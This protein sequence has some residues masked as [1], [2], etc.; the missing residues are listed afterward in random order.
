MSTF[1]F[2]RWSR[3]R[4]HAKGRGLRP[5]TRRRASRL[6]QLE[7]RQLLAAEL[8]NLLT[9][10]HVDLNLQHESGQWQLGVEADET[11]GKVH[12]TNDQAL[13]YAGSPARVVMPEGAPLDFVGVDPGENFYLLPQSQAQNAEALFLG[14]AGYGLDDTVDRYDASAES[15]GRT[16]A[17]QVR[18]AKAALADVRHVNPD[19]SAGSG[20]FSMWQS[21]VF[22]QTVVFM[23]SFDDGVANANALG[24]DTTDG[25]SADDAVWISTGSHAHYNFGFTQPGRYEVDLRLS[26]Y[27]GDDNSTTPNS[28]GF[29]Q[30]DPITVY[31]SVE[32]VGQVQFDASSYSVDEDA[33]TA[34]IDVVRTGGSDGRIS[35]NYATGDATAVA[36]SD[37]TPMSGEIVLADGQT[38]KTIEIPILDDATAEG[39][40]S[41]HVGLMTPLPAGID[42]YL[43]QSEDDANGLLGDVVS[44]T[45]TIRANDGSF[46]V[47]GIQESYLPGEVL[48][49]R[50]AGV[51][52]EEGQE[53]QWRIRPAGTD[54]SG[55]VLSRFVPE[56][57]TPDARAGLLDMQL[58]ASFDGYELVAAVMQDFQAIATTKWAGPITVSNAVEPLSITYNG[59]TP[60]RIGETASLVATGRELVEGESLK[61]VINASLDHYALWRSA[62]GYDQIDARTFAF[63]PPSNNLYPLALQV[64]R[65][66]LVV[67]QSESFE[68]DAERVEFFFE[69][70]QP[71]YRAGQTFSAMITVDP[72]LGDKVTYSWAM[73]DDDQNPM[74]VAQGEAGRTFEMPLTAD[75]DG[76]RMYIQ[77]RV[78]YESGNTALVGG[79]YPYLTVID[80]ASD[81]L[82]L[83]SSL[84]DHYHQGSPVDLQLFADPGLGEGDSIAWQ[85]RW[86]GMDWETMPGAEG[87][88]HQLTAEQAMDGLEVRATLTFANSN[89]DPMAAGPVTIEIDDHGSAPLQQPT[90]TG[91]LSVIGDNLVTLTRQLPT[92]VGT[93]LTSHLWERKGAGESTFSPVAG[94][95][96]ST[97]TFAA[98]MADDGAEY[99]VS[100]LKPDGTVAY[101]PSP[102]VVLD[103]TT[104]PHPAA[105]VP[106]A[107]PATLSTAPAGPTGAAL[108]DLDGDGDED[109]LV[110]SFGSVAWLP[111]DAGTF[112][113]S[114]TVAAVGADEAVAGD[115]DGDGDLDVIV[116][117][118]GVGL[119]WYPN[120]GSGT[121]GSR[122]V[123]VDLP[124]VSPGTLGVSLADLDGDGDL[125]AVANNREP[126]EVT[127]YANDGSGN[128]AMAAAL[129]FDVPYTFGLAFADL[130][131]D[132]D[133]D[134]AAANFPLNQILWA[135]ND[136]D[137]NFGLTLTVTS[138][139]TGP[140][141]VIAVDLDGDSDLDLVSA[142][143]DDKVA[144]YENDGSGNFGPQQILT[145]A[146]LTP[147]RLTAEDLNGDGG[148]DVIVGSGA[149]GD[150]VWLPGNGAGEFEAARTIVSTGGTAVMATPVVDLDG[151]GDKDVLAAA[152]ATAVMSIE[153]RTGESATAVFAPAAGTYRTGQYVNVGVY[154]GSP[155]TVTGSPF[156]PGTVGGSAVEFAY[157]G[158]SGTNTLTFR[159]VVPAGA[160]DSDGIELGTS[161]DPNGGTL[162]DVVGEVITGNDLN[163]PATDLSGV[164]IDGVAPLVTSITRIDTNPTVAR[165]VSFRVEFD[166]SVSGVDT[167]DFDVTADGVAGA[168]VTAVEGSGTTYVVTVG[169]GFGSGTIRLDVLLHATVTNVGGNSLGSGF[170]GGQVYTLNRRP[171]RT[172]STFYTAGHADLGVN[173]VDGGWKLSIH[174]D[175]PEGDYATD[176][177]LTIAGPSS[178]ETVPSGSQWDFLGS[179]DGTVFVLPASPTADLPFLGLGAEETTPGTFA[180]YLVDDPRVGTT[181][182][183]I[184]LDLMD[185]RGPAGGEFSM[186]S[187]GSE[188]P[189]VWMAS[190]DGLDALDS[191]WLREG[192]HDHT[193]MAFTEAGFYEIDVV[194]S[195]FLD[196]N[197]NG[198]LDPG[199]DPYTESGVTTLY[200]QVNESGEP[201]PVTLPA[202]VESIDVQLVPVALPSDASLADLPAGI[203]SIPVGESYFVEVWVQD[204][205]GQIGGIAGGRIDIQ[206]TTDLLDALQL[207]NESFDVLQSGEIDDAA[208]LIDDFGGGTLIQQQALAPQWARLGYVEVV[209][210]SAGDA[211]Y[212]LL[213]GSLQFA[214]F[215]GGNVGF[216]DV[217]LSDIATVTHTESLQLDFAVV[218]E[219]SATRGD[220]STARVPDSVSYVH[221]W[222]PF[223]VEVYLS[224]VTEMAGVETIAFD[225]SYDTSITTAMKFKPGPSFEFSNG[226]PLLDDIAGMISNIQLIATDPGLGTEPVLVGHVL[227]SPTDSDDVAVDEAGTQI[228][229][230]QGIGLA[231]SAV[232]DVA[233][234]EVNVV[235]GAAP[236]T[237]MWAVPYDV[238]DSD[239]I[240]FADFAVFAAAFGQTVGDAEP[241]FARW[242]DFDGSGLVDYDDLAY[243]DANQGLTVDGFERLMFS[244]AYPTPE[245]DLPLPSPPPELTQAT[246]ETFSSFGPFSNGND[247]YDVDNSG[248]TSP[249]DA[250]LVINALASQTNARPFFL[251]VNGDGQTSPMDALWVINRLSRLQSER[252]SAT[253]E[254]LS[255]LGVSAMSLTSE[256]LMSEDSEDDELIELIAADQQLF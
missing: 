255:T 155:V 201:T 6:E 215:G 13:L 135:A 78:A 90:V 132:G 168:S 253:D 102:A 47:T 112:G 170:T 106:F 117:E 104:G 109:L 218:R 126:G 221:E 108:A 53:V 46:G 134:V 157:V 232:A 31:F 133:Q 220:G 63:E 40:E 81:Q 23:S 21:G 234:Q 39:D 25:I 12:Y 83:F 69:G 2:G 16:G 86:P 91:E 208:G 171:E 209:A 145:T 66:G 120:D 67:A 144:V 219:P 130:D 212:R 141:S 205:S 175:D 195:G 22:G 43:R 254:A 68:V 111:L 101:G 148:V 52:L 183:W 217:D 82:F 124:G 196:A 131:G 17:Q 38:R 207:T 116:A 206:Y 190:A 125:D 98:T 49:A 50:I 224:N 202:E 48:Q 179:T 77:A 256:S 192:S 177:I 174:A 251:D 198:T 143:Y 172:L 37:Y 114:I 189:R 247:A 236:P 203:D 107:L 191:Y 79:A 1:R 3:S 87:L 188:G 35:V 129:P 115:L 176:E 200:F 28:A 71:V 146:V 89:F 139:L 76:Q 20:E 245:F 243:F 160:A 14:V 197:G 186:Y 214:T 103:V 136:G 97:L 159:Y 56:T 223:Y 19:G 30:S 33:G 237:A 9:T 27:F 73:Y 113:A 84:P 222:E 44:T 216:D 110:P 94:Q 213:P 138:E 235:A 230:P 24:L 128:F 54:F 167:T 70:M 51:T 193:N 80:N 62:R 211:E 45:V 36:D 119:A 4:S 151:D 34:S 250:L 8:E 58:D 194:A 74:K 15:K 227:F 152:Y 60:F 156:I 182:R 166:Q 187:I 121:F 180:A 244:S 181:S 92:D 65:D 199:M 246:L 173:F 88:N 169:T 42:T 161:I 165:S 137:G 239:S 252:A 164:L 11:G 210:T 5:A 59:P 225:L 231:A 57:N 55:T 233:G 100:I 150:V 153:N 10:Q 32:S 85:W 241:P 122:H 75:L 184:K 99:R 178:A 154:F 96:G 140:F 242:A 240:D 238:D 204:R 162:V 26:A 228:L 41:F 163:V 61:V 7:R 105:V 142:S 95:S 149:N 158:G 118:T 185:V 229:G 249:R 226:L 248:E 127:W 64:I 72:D 29:S 147:Y 18:W 123:I 93:I